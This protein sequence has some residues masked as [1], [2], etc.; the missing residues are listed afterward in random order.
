MPSLRAMGIDVSVSRGMDVVLLDDSLQPAC[1]SCRTVEAVED[2]LLIH[3][4]VTVAI[5]A[6]PS[7]PVA[8]NKRKSE[9]DLHALGL[10]IFFS[11]SDPLQ[12]THPFYD[13]MRVGHRVFEAARRAGYP[14]YLG[15]SSVR[16]SALEVYPHATAVLLHGSPPPAGWA[17]RA[18]GKRQWRTSVLQESGVPT[19]ALVTMDL[20]DAA[21][22]ALTARLALEGRAVSLG[23]PGEEGLVIPMPPPGWPHPLLRPQP[24]L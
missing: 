8:G 9:G 21:L 15:E 20:V 7:F 3:R 6:P 10:H 16:G 18:A 14:T 2:L 1:W 12:Q 17:K 22:A 23:P 19:P 13:W 24:L 4:P 5:D 11:P